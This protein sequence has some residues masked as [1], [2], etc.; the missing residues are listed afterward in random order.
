MATVDELFEYISNESGDYEKF[1]IAFAELKAVDENIKNKTNSYGQPLLVYAIGYRREAI[2]GYLLAEG[3]D[4]NIKGMGGRTPLHIAASLEDN[5]SIVI[6]LINRDANVVNARD[7]L[8]NTPLHLAASQGAL[9]IA[10]LL[11]K[12]G[13]QIDAINLSGQ[14]PLDLATSNGHTRVVKFLKGKVNPGISGQ[15]TTPG[16]NELALNLDIAATPQGEPTIANLL[17]KNGATNRSRQTMSGLATSNEDIQVAGP[18]KTR[19]NPE[20]SEKGGSEEKDNTTSRPK[21]LLKNWK[22]GVAVIM[23]AIVGIIVGVGLVVAA[24]GLFAFGVSLPVV[25]ATATIG[26]AGLVA[27]SSYFVMGTVI[28]KS[29]NSK[30]T[31]TPTRKIF[32]FTNPVNQADGSTVAATTSYDKNV[33]KSSR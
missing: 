21:S 5:W 8:G 23:P 11:I 13:A 15:G 14:T 31:G 9:G 20:I 29:M 22:Y 2:V 19:I 30:Q 32:T 26:G 10:N 7:S 4:V 27:A 33:N 17:I 24:G 3:A 25:A 18:L 28:A 6:S 1:K 16:R 12:N